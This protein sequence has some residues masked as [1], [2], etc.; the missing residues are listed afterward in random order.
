MGFPYDVVNDHRDGWFADAVFERQYFAAL[1]AREPR[2][3]F[4]GLLPGQFWPHAVFPSICNLS[5]IRK[6]C[7]RVKP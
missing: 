5:N 6:K 2:A 4:F 1:A 3:D 7:P